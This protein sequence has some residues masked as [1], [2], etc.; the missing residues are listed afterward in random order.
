MAVKLPLP[1][2]ALF[3]FLTFAQR[4]W[5]GCTQT[6]KLTCVDTNEISLFSPIICHTQPIKIWN[7][8]SGEC[9]VALEK[10]VLGNL[11]TTAEVGPREK[12][13]NHK[14]LYSAN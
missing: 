10:A 8:I 4:N 5:F 1:T 14:T 6:T 13:R 9:G 7:E 11:N 12:S 3:R 2:A